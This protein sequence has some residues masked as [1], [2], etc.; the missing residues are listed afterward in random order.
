MGS[1]AYYPTVYEDSNFDLAGLTW[2]SCPD[3]NNS[4]T[5][6]R[7]DQI[8]KLIFTNYMG[9]CNEDVSA[10]FDQAKD[11]TDF[12]VRKELFQEIQCLIIDD[13]PAI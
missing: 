8:R 3:S 4:A 11:E 2:D 13:A 12:E 1:S 10:L 9:Y 5:V 6:Y 7:C